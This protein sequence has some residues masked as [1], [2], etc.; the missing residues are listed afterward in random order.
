MPK[1]EDASA[2]VLLFANFGCASEN[3]DSGGNNVPSSN[4]GSD[5]NIS[6]NSLVTLDGSISSDGDGDP[7]SYVWLFTSIPPGSDAVIVACD[8]GLPLMSYIYA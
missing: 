5:Q 8:S 3:S 1:W 2:I 4:A 7:L 6:T